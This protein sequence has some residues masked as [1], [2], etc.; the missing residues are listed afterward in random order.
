VKGA[1]LY[2]ALASVA[3]L[4][5]P[6]GAAVI[7]VNPAV[8]ACQATIQGAV[9]AAV[10]GDSITIA[11]GTYFENVT[12][13]GGKDG[14]KINGAGALTI[15][16]PDLPG[17]G[18]AFN[19]QSANV[20]L[21]SLAIRNGF[22]NV[23]QIAANNATIQ[24]LKIAGVRG[25]SNGIVVNGGFTGQQ[26]ISNDVR[27]VGGFC[28]YL[29]GGNNNSAVKT[30]TVSGCG[31]YGIAALGNSLQVV[32]NRVQLAAQGVIVLGNAATVT[33][34]A[35]E[36]ATVGVQASGQNP[37]VTANRVTSALVGFSLS[38]STCTGGSATAN[39]GTGLSNGMFA[40]ADAAGYTVQGNRLTDVTGPSLQISGTSVLATLNTVAGGNQAGI[41]VA[42]TGNGHTV[43]R[44]VVTRCGG[45]G[46]SS[47]GDNNT[48]D[49]N[50]SNYSNNFGFWIN[51]NAGANSGA[52]LTNNRALYTNAQGFGITAG[53]V[54]TTITGNTGVKNRVDAC[55][56]TGTGFGSGNTFAVTSTTCDIAQ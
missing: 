29:S 14:L 32:G 12:I 18:Q 3:G 42:V 46:F 54:G 43:S 56:T 44:N 47:N 15:V 30:N 19:I 21:K 6:A 52:S 41:C 25:A 33:G 10:A 22:G 50:V 7:C 11:A 39:T 55:N 53:A 34:N 26:I 17:T 36:Q 8:P 48:F 49:F 27:G 51:G 20:S 35:V 1:R 45:A 23:V 31:N 13:P 9:T 5:A 4:S 37:A 16:D 2:V 24:G 38:C 28:I 40:G